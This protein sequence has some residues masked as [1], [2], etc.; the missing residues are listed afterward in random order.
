MLYNIQ[1]RRLYK[2]GHIVKLD[3]TKSQYFIFCLQLLFL[4]LIWLKYIERGSL[5]PMSFSSDYIA[6]LHI[7]K[8]NNAK[9]YKVI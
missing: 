8:S 1:Q 9:L 3:I 6:F 4:I 2:A 5:H 7:P